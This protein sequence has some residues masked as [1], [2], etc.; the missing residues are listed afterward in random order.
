LGD[1]VASDGEKAAPPQASSI[2]PLCVVK[3]DGDN[4]GDD[5]SYTPAKDENDDD[6]SSTL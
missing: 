1:C 2:L 6:E 4:D 3:D 5:A